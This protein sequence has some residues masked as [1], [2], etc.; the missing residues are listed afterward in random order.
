[1]GIAVIAAGRK[2]GRDKSSGKDAVK[3]SA[4]ATDGAR[5]C[6]SFCEALG[7][8]AGGTGAR[9]SAGFAQHARVQHLPSFKSQ[10]LRARDAAGA[11]TLIETAKTL[12]QT[13]TMLT[14][15]ARSAVAAL[16][17]RADISLVTACSFRC[18][19]AGCASGR[20]GGSKFQLL[21]SPHKAVYSVIGVFANFIVGQ[22][23]TTTISGFS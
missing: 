19:V 14:K 12:C 23:L 1:M 13:V 4:E 20:T 11:L 22:K 21:S 6:H 7:G 2:G 15:T 3:V 16:L 9:L 5:A 10:H 17:S 8:A 18:S